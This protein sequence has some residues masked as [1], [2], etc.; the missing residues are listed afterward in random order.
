MNV[1]I[2]I[3]NSGEENLES[4]IGYG[5]LMVLLY[6]VF[7]GIYAI[8]AAGVNDAFGSRHYKANF[9]LLF[10]QSIAYSG[11]MIVMTKIPLFHAHLGYTGMFLVSGGFGII[12]IFVACFLPKHLSSLHH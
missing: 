3:C 4:K 12:S 10:T 11:A 7:P 9:G 1:L 5:I 2:S 8:V 6:M